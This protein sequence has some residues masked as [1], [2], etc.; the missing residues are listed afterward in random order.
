[1]SK[2]KI[3]EALNVSFIIE[4][5]DSRTLPNLHRLLEKAF[6]KGSA[7]CL[8][9]GDPAASKKEVIYRVATPVVV[10]NKV[11]KD[12]F[13]TFISVFKALEHYTPHFTNHEEV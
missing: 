7:L 6:G 1:M 12:Y 2:K 5:V 11:W 13:K 3:P 9:E 4:D 10:N 8:E